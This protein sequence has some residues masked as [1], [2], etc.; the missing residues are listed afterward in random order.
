MQSHWEIMTNKFVSKYFNKIP[1]ILH[2]TELESEKKD[3]GFI[4]SSFD[5]CAITLEAYEKILFQLYFV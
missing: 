5:F 1:L 4:M 2:V 3:I